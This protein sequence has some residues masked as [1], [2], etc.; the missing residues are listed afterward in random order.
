MQTAGISV[1]QIDKRELDPKH[2]AG[3]DHDPHA[4]RAS[5]LG[6]RRRD[7]EVGVAARRVLP[8]DRSGHAESSEVNGQTAAA[9]AQLKD[10]DQIKNVVEPVGDGRHD[11]Q[12]SATLL[13]VLQRHPAGRP[14]ADVG[15][16]QRHRRNVNKLIETQ[17]GACS[18]ACSTA[19]ITSPPTSR[20]SP[21]A[22]AGDVK[23]SIKNVR[24]ITESIKSLVGTSEGEVASDRRQ[25]C[26][27]RSTS[28]RRPIDNLDKT[29]K[30]MERSPR[31][32]TRGRARSGAC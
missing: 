12:T 3:E 19:S 10:G 21:T 2:R 32:S 17:L 7:E 30:N 8:G 6:E 15:P 18:S 14:Q 11:G 20:T 16:D 31:A 24:E 5:A 9:C 27:G 25:P 23:E 28:C 13:P 26:A 29:M 4:A 22:E 1:G